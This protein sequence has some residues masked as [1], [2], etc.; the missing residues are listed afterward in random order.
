[1]AES[2]GILAHHCGTTPR[3]RI[4]DWGRGGGSR[5][6]L[7]LEEVAGVHAGDPMAIQPGGLPGADVHAGLPA[8]DAGGIR[9]VRAEHAA[10]A[11]VDAQQPVAQRQLAWACQPRTHRVTVRQRCRRGRRTQSVT[12]QPLG[13]SPPASMQ[14]GGEM[15]DCWA[16]RVGQLG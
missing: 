15:P 12:R 2:T 9:G 16:G 4:I 5:R 11:V 13:L 7:T 10:Q 8:V 1:M 3:Q 14:G 6:G